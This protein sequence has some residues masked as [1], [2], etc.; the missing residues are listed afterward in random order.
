MAK[1]TVGVTRRKYFIVA[2]KVEV[3]V[4][5]AANLGEALEESVFAHEGTVRNLSSLE[6]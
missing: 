1:R 5:A 2:P 3:Q 4:I 6:F